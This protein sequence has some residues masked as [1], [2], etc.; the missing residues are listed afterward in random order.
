MEIAAVHTYVAA[1]NT[2][3]PYGANIQ[4]KNWN[5]YKFTELQFETQGR[6]SKISKGDKAAKLKI[7]CTRSPSS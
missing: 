5:N 3:P 6:R 2:Y 7:S 4:T 1:K